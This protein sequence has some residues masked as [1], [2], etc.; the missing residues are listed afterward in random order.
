MTAFPLRPAADPVFSLSFHRGYGCGRS[1]RCC[2]AGWDIAVEADV[3]RDL[4]GA[5]ASGRLST[6]GGD[7]AH[8]LVPI[9]APRGAHVSVLGRTTAGACLFWTRDACSIHRE[10]GHAA[11]PLACRQ[12]PRVVLRDDRGTFVTLSHFCPTAAA[13]LVREPLPASIERDAPPY[14]GA[15]LEGLDAT[16]Q[17]PPL[18]RP[19]A[20]MSLDAVTTWEHWVV[21]RLTDERTTLEE[22][23]CAVVAAT[24]RARAWSP[25]GPGIEAHFAD[26]VAR[27][28]GGSALGPFADDLVPELVDAALGAVPHEHRLEWPE[29]IG[30]PVPLGD[31]APVLR[32]YLA[33]RAFGS[34]AL[35]QGKGLR[36]WTRALAA[37]AALAR[38]GAARSARRRS[39]AP[40][41]V[42]GVGAADLVL[43]HLADPAAVFSRLSDDEARPLA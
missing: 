30:P 1:G 15:E 10:L 33:A 41:I 36:T 9:P 42:D 21:E 29:S 35:Y 38:T 13:L 16:G 11:L 7:T 2:T 39:G 24:E 43:L 31:G 5:F 14:A 34:W 12:F 37:A 17:L 4:R 18:L 20:L 40:E 25:R 8:A 27:P 28:P 32:R 6:P 19:D 22:A 26:I 23:L 3:D